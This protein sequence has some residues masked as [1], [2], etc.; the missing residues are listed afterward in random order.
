MSMTR[1]KYFLGEVLGCVI[2]LAIAVVAIGILALM[3]WLDHFR[4]YW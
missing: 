4:F 2:I 3:F 1:F